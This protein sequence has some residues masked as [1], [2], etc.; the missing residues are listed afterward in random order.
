MS[1]PDSKVFYAYPSTPPSA[2]D[3]AETAVRD[4]HRTGLVSV[5]PWEK[6]FV[7]GRLIPS[8]VFAAIDEAGVVIADLTTLNPNVLYEVGYAIGLGKRIW[9]TADVS[10]TSRETIA[11][12]VPPLATLGAH[13]YQN[14]HQIAASFEAEYIKL[15]E[16]KPL[17]DQFH[18]ASVGSHA[19]AVLFLKALYETDASV[20]V[21][22]R[23]SNGSVPAVIDDPAETNA[24]SMSWYVERLLTSAGVL[25]HFTAVDRTGSPAVN[26][27][28]ALVAGMARGV[29]AH[30]LLLQEKSSTAVP[31]DFRDDV[32]A[33]SGG[34]EA[35]RIVDEWLSSI[36]L[37][38]QLLTAK[39]LEDRDRIAQRATLQALHRGIGDFVAENDRNLI[40][41]YFVET[42]AYLE[43]LHSTGAIVFVG[44]KG[45]GKT[46]NFL[47]LADELGRS[48]NNVVCTI[49]PAGYDL[50]SLVE[51]L[52][53]VANDPTRESAMVGLWKYLL[54]TEIVAEVCRDYERRLDA[55]LPVTDAEGRLWE[56]ADKR[57]WMESTFAERLQS[58]IEQPAGINEGVETVFRDQV[59]P[60]V[61]NL[62]EVLRQK[63]RVCVLLDNI[64]KAWS[65]D[66]DFP[67]LSRFLLSLLVA[68]G[69]V[70]TLLSRK[71]THRIE[72]STVVFVR[73]DIFERI[74]RSAREPDKLPA[75]T[76]KW[77]DRELL[78]RV[79]D[80]R[81][82]AAT[83]M[84]GPETWE[85]YFAANIH[86]KSPREYI[87][88]RILPRP[89]D[90]IVFVKAAIALALNRDHSVVEADDI[91][92]AERDYSAYALDSVKVENMPVAD[93]VEEVLIQL[94]YGHPVV[95]SST[96]LEKVKSVLS[97]SSIRDEM[98]DLLVAS[99]ILGR[100]VADD[101]YEFAEDLA[102]ARSLSLRAR[103]FGDTRRIGSRFQVHVALHR[104]LDI[105]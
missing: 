41:E 48:V 96:L 50:A 21:A 4:L 70:H 32:R 87:V 30:H 9:L 63:H 92:Q 38:Q 28:Y 33:Y 7:N 47:K 100:E 3:A 15:M 84:P 67:V 101:V 62:S 68:A 12:S 53:L 27:R 20:R 5:I 46:A 60:A 43:A 25:I 83:G 88:S 104:I 59:G 8:E 45:T 99:S 57:G 49:K 78:M 65:R 79:V 90:A 35:R 69:E 102:G 82:R 71:M 19:P 105:Q 51:S 22:D 85:R 29:K 61:A 80:E 1:A 16:S 14:G 94:M 81:L 17:L 103:R 36:E 6:L 10:R 52:K 40:S 66:A 44:R 89:R 55:R 58:V 31:L 56:Y 64:D 74:R 42:A 86:G 95:E 18:A 39:V 93:D 11:V 2:P 24:R 75:A 26:A 98:I 13:A 91:L 76:M 54:V 34:K 97:D 77:N 37:D 72:L 23:I 73:S